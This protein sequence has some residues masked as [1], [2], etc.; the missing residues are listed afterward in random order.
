MNDLHQL[1][2]KAKY[3]FKERKEGESTSDEAKSLIRALLEPDP[4]KRLKIEQVL[5]HPW[6]SETYNDDFQVEIF[7]ELELKAIQKDFTY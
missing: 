1:I 4:S 7:T 6:L 3:S 5:K 2:I